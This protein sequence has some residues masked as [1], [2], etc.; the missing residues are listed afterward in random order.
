VL[1]TIGVLGGGVHSYNFRMDLRVVYQ[2]LCNNH[3]LP[4]EPAYPLWQGLPLDSKLTRKELD[5]RVD[6]CTG[7]RKPAAE[8]TA[9]QQR[10]LDTLL[11]AIKI[12]ERSLMGHMNWATW[13]FQD[14]AWHR[15]QGRNVFGNENVQYGLKGQ[16]DALNGKVARYR[17][18]PAAVAAFAQDADAEGRIAVPVLTL[19]AVNDPVAFVE[20]ESFFR[21]RMVA[22]GQGDNLVQVFTDDAEHS[23]L[24]DAQYVAAISTLLDWTKGGAK[25]TAAA[26]AKRCSAVE[27]EFEPSKGCR[28]VPDYRPAALSARVPAR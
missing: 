19:H 20:L 6:A 23:Y 28:L 5:D 9:E 7:V 11:R 14:I 8:R 10:K 4:D 16:D 22:G 18:D 24:S 1:L 17:A 25:P 15:M 12:Q 21:E 27:P 3:P 2:A 13:H 26:L